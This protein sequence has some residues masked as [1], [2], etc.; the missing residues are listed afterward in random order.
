LC[1]PCPIN[2][3]NKIPD[4]SRRCKQKIIPFQGNLIDCK[5]RTAP[6]WGRH[7][8]QDKT[9]WPKRGLDHANL[10][11]Q[12]TGLQGSQVMNEVSVVDPRQDKFIAHIREHHRERDGASQ[13]GA[14]L[15]FS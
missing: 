8:E 14:S 4:L 15:V 9:K 2:L 7:D 1:S 3:V 11:L 12:P 13:T 10:D 5:P 6:P